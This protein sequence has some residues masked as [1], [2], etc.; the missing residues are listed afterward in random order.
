MVVW[1]GR[2]LAML[3]E[4]SLEKGLIDASKNHLSEPRTCVRD[5]PR[6]KTSRGQRGSRTRPSHW[7]IPLQ[8]KA[9]RRMRWKWS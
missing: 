3:S 2:K 8:A 5:L 6:A 1:S 9:M 4:A 7:K